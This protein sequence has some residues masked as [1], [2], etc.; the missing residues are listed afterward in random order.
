[1]CKSDFS[2]NLIRII[3]GCAISLIITLILL[4]IFACILTY[5]NVQ[6]N[7]IKPVVIII[8]IISIL[9]GSSISTMK[10]SKNGL[11]NGGIIGFIYIMSIYILSSIT[12]SSFSLNI[13]SIIMIVTTI[14]SGM[15]GGVIGVNYRW[16]RSK[17]KLNVKTT[18]IQPIYE[19]WLNFF[20]F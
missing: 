12:G 13:G 5:T 17:L 18:K 3:K 16:K 9:I 1:M 11:L 7:V 10:L 2:K 8:S 20:S 19:K 4:F 6:E 14:I 15:I